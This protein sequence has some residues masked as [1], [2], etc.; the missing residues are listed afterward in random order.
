MKKAM[1]NKTDNR[2]FVGRAA[3]GIYLILKHAVKKTGTVIVPANICYAGVYPVLYAGMRVRFCDVDPVSGNA[4]AETFSSAA[5]HDTVA[6]VVPH[7]YGNPVGDLAEIA[8]FCSERGILLIEDCAS[9]MG[10][11]TNRYALGE[12]GDYAVYSTGYSKTVDLGFGGYV[13]GKN[14]ILG[15]E[16]AEKLLPRRSGGRELALFSK[17]YRVLRNEGRGT[18]LERVIYDELQNACRDEFIFSISDTERAFLR[19][20]L[21]NA[22]AVIRLRREALKYYEKVLVQHSAAFYPF[23]EGAVP[24]RF[25]MLISDSEKKSAIIRRC[26]AEG[27]PVSDWYPNVTY[28]FGDEGDYPG[29]DLHETQIINFPLLLSDGE[30][31][32][33]C[34]VI[35]E[36]LNENNA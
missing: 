25:C 15:L 11:E 1:E 22:D 7:M 20:G 9:A 36:V 8:S 24:W 27:L 5:G 17:L 29:A 33:I 3:V 32:R 12:Q 30:K 4:T 18:K 26:L 28:L 21:E 16:T 2:L 34:S 19:K 23:S 35:N 31:D 14:D 10:A 6:A 13:V